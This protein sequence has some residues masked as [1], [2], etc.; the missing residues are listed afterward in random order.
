MIRCVETPFIPEGREVINLD[1]RTSQGQ[2]RPHLLKKKIQ[3][4]EEMAQWVAR[5]L[6]KNK[7]LTSAPRPPHK[8]LEVSEEKGRRDG[9]VRGGKTEGVLGEGEGEAVIEM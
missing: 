9:C 3:R 2:C 7:D 4:H 1:S 5:I 8:N 6:Y